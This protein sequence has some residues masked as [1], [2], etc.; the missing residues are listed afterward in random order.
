MK[1]RGSFRLAL[2]AAIAVIAVSGCQFFLD[3][4]NENSSVR[5]TVDPAGEIAVGARVTLDGSESFDADGNTLTFE[6]NMLVRMAN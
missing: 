3:F 6:W 4:L 5:I 2:V 1:Q